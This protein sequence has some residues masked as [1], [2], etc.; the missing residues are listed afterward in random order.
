M[1][2]C[3]RITAEIEVEITAVSGDR[4]TT[5]VARR[6]GAAAVGSAL[7]RRLAVLNERVRRRFARYTI[8]GS[9][10]E[11]KIPALRIDIGAVIVA[12]IDQRDI[13]KFFAPCA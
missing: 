13:F 6:A 11:G 7:K 10:L 12:C 5:A 1:T 3:R 2:V 8:T 9:I 4:N